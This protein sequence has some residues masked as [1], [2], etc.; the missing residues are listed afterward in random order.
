[1]VTE[2]HRT[3]G[4]PVRSRPDIAIPGAE[5]ALRMR[6]MTEELGEVSEAIDKQ[7]IA[8]LA[9]ELADLVYVAI[10]TAVAYGIPFDA[11]F[12]EVHRANMSK[13][14]PGGVPLRR[15]DGKIVKPDSF[16]AADL[17]GAIAAW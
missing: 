8:N 9:G 12:A 7:D 16:Q 11:V 17:A 6:L 15:E 3:F 13:L 1:M 4:L 5:A 10:G 14:G 2:F